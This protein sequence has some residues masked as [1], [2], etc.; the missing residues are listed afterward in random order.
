ME[1][2]HFISYSSADALEFALKLA[3]ALI[4]RLFN[5]LAVVDTAG[6]LAGVRAAVAGKA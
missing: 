2:R 5:A 1:N 4:V 6:V 3:D